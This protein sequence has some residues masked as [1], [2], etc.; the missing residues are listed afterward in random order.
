[1][2]HWVGL[3]LLAATGCS[4]C[5]GPR[6]IPPDA[7]TRIH[8][9]TDVKTALFTIYPEFRGAQV[10][11]GSYALVRTVDRKVPL[12]G[13]VL[14]SVKKNEFVVV[15]DGGSLSATRAPYSLHIEG[16][17][18]VLSLPLVEAD[19]GKLLNAP[20]TMTTE[21]LAIWFPRLPGA[22][23]IDER[24]RMTL[25]YDS[26]GWRAGYLAWQMVEL[27]THGSW[28]VEAYPEGYEPTRKAD[29]GGGTTAQAYSLALVDTNTTA[30][31]EVHRDGGL[32]QLD[33]ELRTEEFR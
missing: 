2:R 15:V 19:V 17:Q 21:Q 30:R 4:R 12:D 3:L 9:S 18:L 8:R 25:L 13:D 23:V 7:G 10:V 5:E 16:N 11:E 24:F 31:L 32:V 1:M 14:L 27:N 29:G 6:P 26:P 28:R 33:Y 22:K 20:V